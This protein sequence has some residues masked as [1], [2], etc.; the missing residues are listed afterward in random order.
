[1]GVGLASYVEICGFGPWETGTVSIDEQGK[2]TVLSGTSPHGQGHETTW[3]QIVAEG[4]QVALEDVTVL[5]GDTATVPK[6]IGTFGSRSAAVGGSAIYEN[7]E[8]VRERA[9]QIAAHMLEAAPEDM[10]MS[11]GR[12]HVQGVPDRSVSLAEVAQGANDSSLPPELRGELRS[13]VRY[14][15]QGETYPFGTHICVVEVDPDTGEIEIVRYVSVDDCG[16]VI[17]PLIVEGQIHGGAAQGIGQALFEG[18]IYDEYGNLLTG[19]L[20]DYA[21]PRADSLPTFESHRTET[22]SPLNA[23]GVKGIGEAATIGSTP[24]TV[25]AVIDA[26]SHLGVRHLDMP[27]TAE[28]VW[29]AM[30]SE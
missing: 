5:H 9:L 12:L 1:M 4:L 23:L 29:T 25:N 27:L 18:A 11:D 3:S 8:I 21:L 14:K 16:R 13:E 15:P 28:R 24:A 20:M 19:S 26:L 30:Q 17:N 2:V 10:T 22:P 6:G 7:T